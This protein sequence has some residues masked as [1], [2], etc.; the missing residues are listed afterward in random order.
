MSYP[1]IPY[2]EN[3]LSEH[4]THCLTGDLSLVDFHQQESQIVL[5]A[6]NVDESGQ[7]CINIQDAYAL[8]L[9][10]IGAATAIQS[11]YPEMVGR[12]A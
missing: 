11:R 4:T 5:D 7:V 6:N 10:L 9:W 12:T 1:Q 2:Q 8:G 3:H